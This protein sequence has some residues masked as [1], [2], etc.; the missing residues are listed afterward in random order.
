MAIVINDERGG[1]RNGWFGIAL[2]A[3]VGVI[4]LIAVYYL[5][6]VQPDIVGS[7]LPNAGLSSIDAITSLG[8]DPGTVVS[9]PMF[10]AQ[11]QS[12][13][14]PPVG[15]SGNIQPFGTP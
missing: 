11:R 1:N 9:S 10:T 6:F 5:F 8:F 4:V 13:S 7:A 3:L 15:G 14:L 2:S 12:I